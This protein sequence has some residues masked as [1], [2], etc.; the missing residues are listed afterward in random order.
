MFDALLEAYGPTPL[1]YLFGLLVFLSVAGALMAF[2]GFQVHVSAAKRLIKADI[3][4]PK[5]TALGQ[6]RRKEIQDQLRKQEEQRKKNAEGSIVMMME[7]AGVKS[8]AAK[9]YIKFAIIGAVLT[10]ALM[11]GGVPPL[12]AIAALPFSLVILPKKVLRSKIKKIHKKFIAGF[13]DAIDVLVRGVRTGLPV[14]EG[15]RLVS[16][17]MSAPVGTEF[18]HITDATSVGVTLDDALERFYNRMPLPEVNFFKIVLTIQKQ[19][20]GNLSEALGN[21]S[22]TLRERKKLK[23]RIQALSSE[24]KASAGIIGSLPVV[25]GLVLYAVA[26]DYISL[27]FTT[28]TGNMMVAGGL[29]WMG[30]GIFVMKSMIDIDI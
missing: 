4:K 21:L 17:E 18:T 19:T 8:T 29:V 30:L 5:A 25:L 7:R 24:A 13:P 22:N 23:M 15:M 2:F 27:L 16:R 14:N 9:L 1:L 20:G 10:G 11:F 26:P 12:F 28:S 3:N 6:D